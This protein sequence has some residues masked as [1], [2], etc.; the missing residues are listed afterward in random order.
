MFLG[1]VSNQHD[2]KNILAKMNEI[3]NNI[4]SM[5]KLA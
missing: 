5:S 2:S 4:Y 3:S 1:K